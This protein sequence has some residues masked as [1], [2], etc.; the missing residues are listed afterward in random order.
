M[1]KVTHTQIPDEE[2][3]NEIVKENELLKRELV[4]IRETAAVQASLYEIAELVGFSDYKYFNKVYKKYT[5]YTPNV[6]FPR[7]DAK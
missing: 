5:G 6:I 3:L 7:D 2:T 4:E 1:E